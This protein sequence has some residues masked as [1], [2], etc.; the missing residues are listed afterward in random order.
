MKTKNVTIEILGRKIRSGFICKGDG[1]FYHYTRVKSMESILSEGHIK[2]SKEVGVGSNSVSFSA[3]K[4]QVFP[5]GEVRMTFDGREIG[6]IL[7][8]MVYYNVHV[9]E[10]EI[11]ERIDYIME[12]FGRKQGLGI[13]EIPTFFGATMDI[14]ENECE[15]YSLDPVMANQETLKEITYLIPWKIVPDDWGRS[16]I[17]CFR[18]SP[19]YASFEN[20]Y[21][22]GMDDFLER[23]ARIKKLV[24]KYCIPFSVDSC[25][26][27]LKERGRYADYTYELIDD[28]LKRMSNGEKP[29]PLERNIEEKDFKCKC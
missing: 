8:P 14:Y 1:D 9:V 2:P 15:W 18:T 23:I 20:T 5:S 13:N 29:V 12:D 16:P 10:K 4:Y 3:D 21:A 19:N 22:F 25:Y 17:S 11:G 7:K 26:S 24:E 27:H 28:N 6:S